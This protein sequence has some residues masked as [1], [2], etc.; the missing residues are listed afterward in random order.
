LTA[1]SAVSCGAGF[2]CVL[3]GRSGRSPVSVTSLG[4][5]SGENPVGAFV[6]AQ[7]DVS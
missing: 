3:V 7:K 6:R 5:V 4:G 1:V 2:G